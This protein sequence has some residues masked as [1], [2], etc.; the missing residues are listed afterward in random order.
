[1]RSRGLRALLPL[2]AAT[3]L[4]VLAPAAAGAAT[5]DTDPSKPCYG[6]GDRVSLVGRGF[7][8]SSTV[9]ISRD[10]IRIGPVQSDSRGAI[11]ALA[12]VPAISRTAQTSVYK[13]TDKD[14]PAVTAT[15]RVTL[16]RLGVR[17]TPGDSEAQRPRRIRARGFTAGKFLYAH[18]VR[19]KTRRRVELGRLTGA[20]KT[21]D[22]VRRLFGSR[23]KAGFY[24]VQFDTFR[25]YRPGR[26]QRVRFDVEIKRAPA[27]RG[28]TASHLE[29]RVPRSQV[30]R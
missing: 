22:R 19:G 14:D 27:S 15:R 18:V 6:T 8:P 3:A 23:A 7:T 20:C 24:R 4:P 17:V 25:R 28:A 30:G 11:A 16:S 21:L 13:A 29:V 1:M 5:L 2:L 9:V 12:T 26:A 10:G